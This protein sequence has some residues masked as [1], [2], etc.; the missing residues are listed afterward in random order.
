MN[1]LGEGNTLCTLVPL[2]HGEVHNLI[3]FSKIHFLPAKNIYEVSCSTWLTF[4]ELTLEVR[5]KVNLVEQ[6]MRI[7]KNVKRKNAVLLE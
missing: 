7:R 6:E 4:Q 5:I 2:H 1:L 3:A